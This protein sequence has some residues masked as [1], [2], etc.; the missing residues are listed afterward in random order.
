[1]TIHFPNIDY[2][3][4]SQQNGWNTRNTIGR[5]ITR[6]RN[7]G[8]PISFNEHNVTQHIKGAIE[9]FIKTKSDKSLLAA[10]TAIQVWGGSSAGKHT[11][12][13][14][15]N[16]GEYSKS[17]RKAVEQ[18]VSRDVEKLSIDLIREAHEELQTIKGLGS[19]FIPKHIAFWSGRGDKKAGLPILDDVLAAVLYFTKASKIDYASYCEELS[20]FAKSRHLRPGD[21]EDA[22]FSFA[23]YYWN[24]G[25]TGTAILK[26][27]ALN[28]TDER[29]ITKIIAGN[30]RSQKNGK[31]LLI[32]RVKEAK[33]KT[34]IG[35]ELA[36][37]QK[38]QIKMN[39]YTTLSRR[40]LFE[41]S[42]NQDTL[43]IRTSKNSVC[44][45]D[46]NQMTKLRSFMKAKRTFPLGA[47]MTNPPSDGLGYQVAQLKGTARLASHVAAVLVK[48]GVL[49]WEMDGKQVQLTYCED[50]TR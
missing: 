2:S 34:I 33:V 28:E 22:I 47:S 9:E 4:W 24:T 5:V 30:N 18:I 26:N 17:Y 27:S 19:S 39:S 7:I 50:K 37:A 20:H 32:N 3:Y 21:V 44:T 25:S 36:K 16:W 13:I 8:I 49:R 15:T 41:A 12:D 6:L 45:I 31:S 11:V 10:F 42:Y 14:L 46:S 23:Q 35:I 29:A 38:M 1:M 48:H 43:V 40:K